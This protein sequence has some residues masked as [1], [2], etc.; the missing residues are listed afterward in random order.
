MITCTLPSGLNFIL[1]IHSF[2]GQL[3]RIS[4]FSLSFVLNMYLYYVYHACI[5]LSS[6]LLLL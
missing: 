5:V 2:S 1:S 4:S 6:R 3:C